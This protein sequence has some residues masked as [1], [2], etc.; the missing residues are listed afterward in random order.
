[1]TA[2]A[3]LF[4]VMLAASTASLALAEADGPDHYRVIGVAEDDVLNIRSAPDPT[5]EIVGTIPPRSG[6]LANLGCQGR[7][8][9]TEWQAASDAERDRAA[10]RVWCQVQYDGVTGFVAGRFLAEDTMPPQAE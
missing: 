8:S 6:G 3:R 4:A 2:I 9:F 1:M 5:S 7:L 10:R